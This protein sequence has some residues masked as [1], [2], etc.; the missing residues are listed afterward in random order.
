[1][2]ILIFKISGLLV[3]SWMLIFTDFDFRKDFWSAGAFMDVDFTDLDI[4][5]FWGVRR[6][7]HDNTET[8]DPGQPPLP[9]MKYLLRISPHF[10]SSPFNRKQEKYKHVFFCRE[11]VHASFFVVVFEGEHFLG[12]WGGS[13]RSWEH[14]G[15]FQRVLFLFVEANFLMCWNLIAITLLKE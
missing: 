5:W 15:R 8:P 3:P 12:C 14:A 9:G 10:W 11:F 4:F 1:M 13:G 2:G 7:Q 6:Q